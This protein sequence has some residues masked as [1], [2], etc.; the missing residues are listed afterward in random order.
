MLF[1]MAELELE[2]LGPKAALPYYQA[3][4]SDFSKYEQA[5]GRAVAIY[6]DA[7]QYVTAENLLINSLQK[8]PDIISFYPLL[9]ALYEDEQR[10]SD[11]RDILELGR[12]RYPEEES[13][14]YYLGFVYDRVGEKAKGFAT[15]ESLLALNPNNANALNFLGYTLLERNVELDRAGTYLSTALRLKPNDA[16]VID[17]FGWY[18]FKTGQGSQ[19]MKLLERAHAIKPEE[20]LIVEH[21][22]DVYLALNLKSK[23]LEAYK[24]SYAMSLEVALKERVGVKLSNLESALAASDGPSVRRGPAMARPPMPTER[25]PASAKK[26][27][28]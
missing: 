7:K 27:N 19:A 28:Y 1:Y 21:L 4:S 9:A 24:K 10:L 13:I 3:I 12:K 5:T 18:L 8:R 25:A 6:R 2:R 15:M 16:F 17:S 20:A 14:L 23:A 26:T 11:A 22:A